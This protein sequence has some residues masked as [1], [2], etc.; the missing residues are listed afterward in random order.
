MILAGLSIY[1][2]LGVL[3]LVLS[4]ITI[5]LGLFHKKAHVVSVREALGWTVVWVTTAL[6]FNITLY[7]TWDSI[8]QGVEP[9]M[10]ELNGH[11]AAMSFL[12]GYLIELAL[13]VD[14]IF[15]FIV[16]FAFFQV[17]AHLQHRVLFYGI[18]G[19]L[20]FRAIFI[21]LGATILHHFEWSM[22]LF[23]LFLVLTG[24]KMGTHSGAVIEPEKNGLLKLIRRLIPVTN[25]F[26]GQRFFI[27]R[28]GKW[29]ATPLFV[30]LI[31]I[32]F[33]DVIF[34]VD[35]IPA[36]FAVTDQPF[37]VFTSNVFAIL[38]LR[39]LFFALAGAVRLFHYLSYGLSIVLIFVGGKMLYGYFQ[40]SYFVEEWPKFPI[41][42]SLV[43]IAGI[44][45][46]SIV[47]SILWPPEK[48]EEI[49]QEEKK[50][51]EEALKAKEDSEN[52]YQH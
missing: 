34:A 11:E 40:K 36:I 46:L 12:A 43:I 14:N 38:G 30:T 18:V 24:F 32:E 7:F 8:Y 5:D 49:D 15:V 17:P 47:A 44:I 39:S 25:D 10:H 45:T 3:A 26:D 31:F 41:A 37:I 21:A 19:A 9:G 48:V 52:P 1:V 35:S 23:G 50:R 28:E 4:I 33:T 6:L 29:I 22:V 16:V 51:L 42:A 13:S 2:W 20:V 27:V